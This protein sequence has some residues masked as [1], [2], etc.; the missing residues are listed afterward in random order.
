MGF[1]CSKIF[2]WDF[3]GIIWIYQKRTESCRNNIHFEAIAHQNSVHFVF[4]WISKKQEREANRGRMRLCQ[5]EVMLIEF[6]FLQSCLVKYRNLI[7]NEGGV[8]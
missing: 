7:E 8:A 6:V 1:L 3:C 2:F 4:F 5:R